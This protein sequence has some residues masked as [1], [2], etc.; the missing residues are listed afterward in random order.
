V[1]HSATF[2]FWPATR[3]ALRATPH[4][5]KPLSV[6]DYEAKTGKVA[7]DRQLEI[8]KQQGIDVD[9]TQNTKTGDSR[10]RGYND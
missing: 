8:W 7:K 3:H 6:K 1:T 4:G 9:A 2:D 10:P 5:E